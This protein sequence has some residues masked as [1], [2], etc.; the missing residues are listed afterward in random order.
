M[1]RDGRWCTCRDECGPLNPARGCP[2]GQMIRGTALVMSVAC[3]SLAGCR[4]GSSQPVPAPTVQPQ[5]SGTTETLAWEN[6]M[7]TTLRGL[8]LRPVLGVVALPASPTADALSTGRL[9][10][11]A[12]HGSSPSLRGW[13]G[14]VRPSS[15]VPKRRQPLW[16]SP[17]TLTRGRRH[18][19][20]H[21]GSVVASRH[22]IGIGWPSSVATM[23]IRPRASSFWST[24]RPD[25]VG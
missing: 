7:G 14:Q 3:L 9:R 25:N 13:S 2:T 4:G 22:D 12:Y 15:Y 23:S 16:G 11:R 20:V 5:P 1:P 19:R 8:H 6:G 17:G 24:P 18:R 21:S 10:D